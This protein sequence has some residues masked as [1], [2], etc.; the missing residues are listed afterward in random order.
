MEDT[1]LF[2][3]AEGV[4]MGAGAPGPRSRSAWTRSWQ[5]LSLE[6][7]SFIHAYNL[8]FSFVYPKRDFVNATV[9]PI[10]FLKILSLVFIYLFIVE[11]IVF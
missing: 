4:G 6:T 10:V 1:L 2:F 3:N 5:Q 7:V 8:L 11:S 9:P